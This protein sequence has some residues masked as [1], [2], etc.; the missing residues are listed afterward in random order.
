MR[1]TA[2]AALGLAAAPLAASAAQATSRFV[3][4]TVTGPRSA[5]ITNRATGAVRVHVGARE[6]T[7]LASLAK[8]LPSGVMDCHEN[9]VLYRITFLT[10]SSGIGAETITG[11]R[12]VAGVSIA[13]GSSTIVET[14]RD[15]NCAL[16]DAVR[17]VLPRSAVAA[18]KLTV[19]CVRPTKKCVTHAAHLWPRTTGAEVSSLLGP[20]FRQDASRGRS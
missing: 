13:L 19:P 17:G 4:A 1:P 3:G 15:A 7:H 6:A 8:K 16:V 11:W 14:R 18:Q 2:L 12:C 10:T 20:E 5:P 9:R